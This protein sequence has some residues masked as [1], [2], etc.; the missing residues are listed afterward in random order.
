MHAQSKISQDSDS[1]NVMPLPANVVRGEGSF[2]VDDGFTVIFS[3]Y[4]EPRLERAE[5]RMLRTLGRE[6]GILAWKLPPESRAKFIV[7]AVGPSAAVQAVG[8]DESYRLDITAHEVHLHAANPLGVLHGFQTF[9]QLVHATPEGFR[10]NAMSIT[11]APR[12]PWRGLMIDSGRHF[13][14]MEI[15]R[16]NLDAMEAVKLNVLHWH[17]SEDQGFRVESK[18]FPKLQ[19]MG[20]DGQYYTQQDVKDIIAYARDRGIRVYPEF[21]MPSHA[22]SFYVGYPELADGPGP[23]QLKRK[24]G[25]K[26]GR[27]RKASED[28]SM[29]PT[30]ETTYRFLNRL[31]EEMSRLFPDAYWHMGGDGE[32]AMT[33][34]ATNPHIK[35]Y[36]REHNMKDTVALQT[37]FTR[38]LVAIIV[39]H[40]KVPIGW[41]EL[42]QASTPEDVVIQSWRGLDS[43]SLAAKSG[44]QAILSWGYYLD[45]NEPASRH[46][47]V[48]PLGKPVSDLPAKQQ[49]AVLGGEAAMWTEYVSPATIDGRIW[50]RAAA[51]A[52]RLWSPK[53]VNNLDSIYARLSTLSTYLG[54][55][56][57]PFKANRERMYQRVVGDG[58]DSSLKVLA[59]VTAP[60]Q[61]FPREG[62]REYDV[63]TPLNHLSDVIPAESIEARR[64][65]GLM[66]KVAKG[67]ASKT[68]HESLREALEKLRDNDSLLQPTLSGNALT[69]ELIPVSHDISQAAIIGLGALDVLEHHKPLT[70]VDRKSTLAKFQEL[71]AYHAE[72]RDMIIPGV[73]ELVM[74]AGPHVSQP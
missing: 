61:G 23:Y 59:S 35:K 63:Y 62:D 72:L 11:D 46:Y 26:W 42:L 47:L 40:H 29:D 14:P 1:L 8:E 25:E 58:D 64:L 51:V 9:L 55:C 6:T 19:G 7:D 73:E 52:E 17:I 28:S 34:W 12:F 15:I 66:D 57:L 60:P 13:M 53:D 70:D 71:Y 39:S 22:D 37:Y 44:H 16:Q 3:G 54:D 30:R 43:L 4:K 24:F 65:N 50:P 5:A 36:M 27:P 68:E 49:K 74:A 45:L 10:V 33:E 48:D 38:R 2:S 18:V 32:D 20:S 67:T 31:V 41:D 69:A 21:E 56:G